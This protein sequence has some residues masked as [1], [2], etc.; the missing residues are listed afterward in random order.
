MYRKILISS[1]LVSIFI[2]PALKTSEAKELSEK[3]KKLPL[4]QELFPDAELLWSKD[5]QGKMID[6]KIAKK[7]GH[8][9]IG[10]VQGDKGYVYLFSQE[11]K[12]LWMKESIKHSEIKKCASLEL[13]ISDNGETIAVRW[14]GDYEREEI[15]VYDITGEKLYAQNHGMAGHKAKVSPEGGYIKYDWLFNRY[16]KKIVL[17]DVLLSLERLPEYTQH[18]ELEIFDFMSGTELI[19]L[20]NNTLYLF[21]FPE[22]NLKWKKEGL[23][24][25]EMFRNISIFEKNI[26]VSGDNI[27][28]WFNNNGELIWKKEFNESMFCSIFSLSK[29][30]KYLAIYG[31]S[32]KGKIILL[33]TKTGETKVYSPELESGFSRPNS[34]MICK[35]QKILLSGYIIGDRNE[36][37]KGFWSYILC[38]DE[39]W[40]IKSESWKKGLVMGNSSSDIIGVY[41]SN[42]TGK[43]KSGLDEGVFGYE[44]STAFT[45]NILQT[46]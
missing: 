20:L 38:F 34:N 21:S 29:D 23:K 22:G 25:I 16:G 3:A 28:Y 46:K 41:E 9:T 40:N 15:Q 36:L 33:D 13:S 7:S 17:K 10:A 44:N 42:A 43:T 1:I 8:T 6:L 14:F 5:F 45:I 18:R 30:G 26:L 2:C 35:E 11:G 37:H 27:L 32:G 12:L 24:N 31:F 4:T 19:V 39:N